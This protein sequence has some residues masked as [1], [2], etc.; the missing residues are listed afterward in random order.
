MACSALQLISTQR[1]TELG[2]ANLT[3]AVLVELLPDA[4]GLVLRQA[5]AWREL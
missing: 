4:D 5:R 1:A 3:V 2:V